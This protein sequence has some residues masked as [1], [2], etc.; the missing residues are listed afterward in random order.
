MAE[1]TVNSPAR[2]LK[3]ARRAD[4]RGT[5]TQYFGENSVD[6]PAAFPRLAAGDSRRFSGAHQ[7]LQLERFSKQCAWCNRFHSFRH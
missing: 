7:S 3:Q 6:T 5:L 1:A 2:F 4:L